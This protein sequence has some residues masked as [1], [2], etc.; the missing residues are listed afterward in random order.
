MSEM[1]SNVYL[2]ERLR[3]YASK[4]IKA[5]EELYISYGWGY[6]ITKLFFE[7]RNGF[8]RIFCMLMSDTLKVNSK[9]EIFYLGNK[10]KP[11]NFLRFV[12]PE[13]K[14]TDWINDVNENVNGRKPIAKEVANQI[15]NMVRD[16]YESSST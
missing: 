2:D 14:I 16:N 3:A 5:S 10:T 9:H 4:D 11:E 12:D 1:N 7:T 15:I 8:I 6:W 13:S